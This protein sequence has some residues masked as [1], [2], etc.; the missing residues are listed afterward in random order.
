MGRKLVISCSVGF[1]FLSML[2]ERESE[3][4]RERERDGEGEGAGGVTL[5]SPPLFLLLF[6]KIIIFLPHW[7]GL[8][9]LT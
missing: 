7:R 4:D 9:A 8:S 1:L 5:E 3:R 2:R 6:F